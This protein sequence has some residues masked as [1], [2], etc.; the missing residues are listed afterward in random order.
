MYAHT[1]KK[2]TEW[3][4]FLE[5]CIG[6]SYYWWSNR[7]GLYYVFF[8]VFHI[9]LCWTQIVRRM[10]LLRELPLLLE[11]CWQH[12]MKVRSVVHAG[13]STGVQRR[14]HRAHLG[15]RRK[16]HS[17]LDQ[18]LWWNLINGEESTFRQSKDE[19]QHTQRYG[20]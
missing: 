6:W 15:W 18:D 14:E 11:K 19:E 4:L 12:V 16:L 5:V 7:D 13:S 20:C 17:G 1:L 9:L 2:K 3:I 10:H 8:Y